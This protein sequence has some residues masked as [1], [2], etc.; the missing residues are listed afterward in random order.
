MKI[1][2]L[3][4]NLFPFKA[5]FD[6]IKKVDKVV[7][8]DDSFYNSK[9]WV[10]KTVIK[11]NDRRFV[12]NINV[13][14]DGEETKLCDVKINCKNW[15]RNFLRIISSQYKTARNFPI[16]FPLIK[17]I[18]NLPVENICQ[19]SA[20]SIFRISQEFYDYKGEFILSSKKYKKIKSGSF[21]NKIID[22]CKYERAD[23]F[24]TFSMYRETFDSHYFTKNNISISYFESPNK[25]AYSCI[26]FLMNDLDLIKKIV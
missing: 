5:Y 19:I 16:V 10:N 4:P 13:I 24:Y 11:K 14:D 23:H 1:T 3:Q 9:T 22:I 18:I 15:K 21:R 25:T 17:E 20:Y 8:F 7:F 26:D 12:F 2:V 6:L